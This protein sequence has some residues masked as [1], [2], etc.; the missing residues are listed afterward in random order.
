MV[1]TLRYTTEGALHGKCGHKHKNLDGAVDCIDAHEALCVAR[2][3][4]SD[5]KIFAIGPGMKR[6]LN[7]DELA[8]A[9]AY[10]AAGRSK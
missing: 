5:R 2:G 4:H 1:N 8:A 6:D 7:E 3:A 9:V 10:R